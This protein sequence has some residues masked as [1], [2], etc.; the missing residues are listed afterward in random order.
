MQRI[1]GGR[2]WFGAAMVMWAGWCAVGVVAQ[3]RDTLSTVESG[4]T[5]EVIGRSRG[6]VILERQAED[7]NY[8]Y[9]EK[10][11]VMVGGGLGNGSTNTYRFLNA[12]LGPGGQVVHYRRVGTCCP[13]PTKNSPFGD[14]GLLEVYE[15]R[16][17]G[18]TTR[19]LYFNWYDKG[20]LAIPAG[21]TARK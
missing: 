16:Y 8:G 17:D 1:D 21:L 10:L 14:T 12:L 9:S 7:A 18:G 13:V 20:A 11:P 4:V 3:S 5:A 19:R 2:L 15:I 6:F